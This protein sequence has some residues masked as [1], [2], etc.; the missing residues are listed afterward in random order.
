MNFIKEWLDIILSL[1]TLIVFI[2]AM[3][4]FS[5]DPDVE[6]DKQLGMNQVACDEKHKRLDEIV[7]E[8]K[9]RFVSINK[10][11]TL[12]KEN[13]IKHIETEMR[14]MSQQQT[15]ILTILEYREKEKI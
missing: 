3:Y 14:K 15:K 13:D 4:R 1:I 2:V 6:A 12:I 8:I 11:I 5:H 7:S 9:D 10:T